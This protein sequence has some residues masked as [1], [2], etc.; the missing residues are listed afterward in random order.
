[1]STKSTIA[2]GDAFHIYTDCFE[3]K[4]SVFVKINASMRSASLHTMNGGMRR[5]ITIELPRGV[6]TE[7]VRKYLEAT[8]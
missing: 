7:I 6:W 4:D 3:P 1:M 5:A 2:H 8:T